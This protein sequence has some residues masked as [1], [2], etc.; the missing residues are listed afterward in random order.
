MASEFW[1]ETALGVLCP[2]DPLCGV[3]PDKFDVRT[4]RAGSFSLFS[5]FLL[6]TATALSFSL[7]KFGGH[8][9]IGIVP[10]YEIM[11]NGAAEGHKYCI[12]L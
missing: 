1:F 6:K 9:L 3:R 4:A 2:P 7:W 11:S 12:P 8:H 10:E 5:L